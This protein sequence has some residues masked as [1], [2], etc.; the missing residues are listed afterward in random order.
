M[1]RQLSFAS[2]ENEEAEDTNGES[3]EVAP[4]AA[5]AIKQKKNGELCEAARNNI[6]V[7]SSRACCTA[8]RRRRQHSR[9]Q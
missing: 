7:L 4:A 5:Q 6:E 1:N 9:T 8:A 3:D 2:A